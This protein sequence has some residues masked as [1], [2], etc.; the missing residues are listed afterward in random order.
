M[1]AIQTLLFPVIDLPR[2]A[3]KRVHNLFRGV[4]DIS[5][6][7]A[8]RWLRSGAAILDVREP[9][10]FA[11]GHVAGSIPI[12]LGELEARASE[13]AAL[14]DRPLV[15]ICH[16]GKRSATACAVLARLGF[17]RTANLAG[18]ILAWRRAS[19]PETRTA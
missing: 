19:L 8:A 3:L 6:P 16:G 2:E 13:I 12:P 14:K 5:A 11:A 10:E 17:R 7:E 1:S 9:S 18:G 15:V 4:R